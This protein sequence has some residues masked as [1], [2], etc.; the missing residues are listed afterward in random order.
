MAFESVHWR[1]AVNLSR[2][3]RLVRAHAR[4][5]RKEH[6]LSSEEMPPLDRQKGD[7]FI[8][9]G[10]RQV[11]GSAYKGRQGLYEVMALSSPRGAAS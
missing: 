8:R 1:S 4:T 6:A 5:A 3:A 2:G 11:R 10:L 9:A 7:P